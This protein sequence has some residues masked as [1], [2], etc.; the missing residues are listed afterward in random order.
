M[1]N[2]ICFY[3]LQHCINL[4]SQINNVQWTLYRRFSA[5]L[6]VW[7]GLNI[8]TVAFVVLGVTPDLHYGPGPDRV[9]GMQNKV[10]IGYILTNG[11]G[12]TYMQNHEIMKFRKPNFHLGVSS[13]SGA[14]RMR[15]EVWA[16]L[17]SAARCLEAFV[18]L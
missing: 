15:S 5:V 1:A 18:I 17:A 12:R 14:Q 4:S 7:H 3:I 6:N 9:K 2:E 11:I 16:I 8:C 13:S 10:N